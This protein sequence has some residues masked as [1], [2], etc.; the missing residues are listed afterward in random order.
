MRCIL[1]ENARRKSRLKRGGGQVRVDW[2]GLEV[3]E[4][5]P[6]DKI[7]LVDEA[8]QSSSKKTGTGEG[9]SAQVFGGLTNKEVAENMGISERTVYRHWSVPGPVCFG[10]SQGGLKTLFGR[11]FWSESALYNRV[12]DTTD[13]KKAED[14]VFLPR[15]R[16]PIRRA[17]GFY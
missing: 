16:S 9:R 6:D 17:Q 3:A 4:P 8:L 11:N 14:E 10:G 12:P 13:D 5:T 2:R 15:C 1:V 7:L